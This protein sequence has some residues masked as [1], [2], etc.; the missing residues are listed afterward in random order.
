MRTGIRSTALNVC[1]VGLG[2]GGNRAALVSVDGKTYLKAPTA[3][4]REQGGVT[5]NPGDFAGRWSRAPES[6]INLDIKEV[7]AAGAIVQGL[8]GVSSYQPASGTQDVNGTP[9]VKVSGTDVDYYLS[10]ANPPKLLRIAGTGTN[11]YQF[12]VTEVS[13]AEIATLFQQLRDQVRALSGARDP[14]V[15]FLPTA[16]IK[17]SNCGVVSCTMKLTVTTLSLGG[18]S[19]VRALMLGKISVGSQSGRTLGTCTDSAT[20]SSGKRINLACTV[21]GGAW[22]S[23]ARSIRGSARYYVQARTVAEAGDAAD[24]LSVIDQ[25]QQRA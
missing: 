1:L 13:A 10:T 14:S 15:R 22:S 7:L 25:E 2:V 11:T 18:R 12:D 8:Q 24:L 9:A 4:W 17:T 16:K 21:S 5:T 3:F 19:R 23:W 6:A 20:A